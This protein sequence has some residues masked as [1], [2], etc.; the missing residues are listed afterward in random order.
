MYLPDDPLF[1]YYVIITYYYIII[2]YYYIVITMSIMSNNT[3][4]MHKST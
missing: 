4:L 2:A 1:Y 3:H